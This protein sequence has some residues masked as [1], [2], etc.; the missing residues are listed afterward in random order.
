MTRELLRRADGIGT[1]APTSEVA[2]Q[3]I[4]MAESLG[5]TVIGEGI[6]TEHR[7][8]SCLS[9]ALDTARAG[10]MRAPFR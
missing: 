7:R 2:L 6:E 8:N 4:Y 10:Y 3:I 1:D 9:A 5:L